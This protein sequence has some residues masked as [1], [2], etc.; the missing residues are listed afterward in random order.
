MGRGQELL[1]RPHDGRAAKGG[2]NE[3]RGDAG[4]AELGKVLLCRDATGG[5]E[6]V[7]MGV[8]IGFGN[9]TVGRDLSDRHVLG[10]IEQ[11]FE[12]LLLFWVKDTL[13]FLL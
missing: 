10:M 13:K 2:N 11:V 3:T 7:Q 9:F 12:N 6:T 5:K 1:R 4:G 8:G